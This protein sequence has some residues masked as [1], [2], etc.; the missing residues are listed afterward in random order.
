MQPRSQTTIVQNHIA[1][2]KV[3]GAAGLAATNWHSTVHF[4]IESYNR[5]ADTCDTLMGL[6]KIFQKGTLQW[7]IQRPKRV[8]TKICIV[9]LKAKRH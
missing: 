6:C 7:Q 1:P 8:S 5:M 4:P 2:Q 9:T 3:H